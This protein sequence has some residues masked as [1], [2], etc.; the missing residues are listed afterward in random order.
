MDNRKNGVAVYLDVEDFGRSQFGTWSGNQD[1]VF[2]H[3]KFKMPS[4]DI[5]WQLDM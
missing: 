5:Q 1:F 3:Y 2:G 4:R